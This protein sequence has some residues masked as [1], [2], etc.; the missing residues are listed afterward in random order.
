MYFQGFL[1]SSQMLGEGQ[2]FLL[3]LGNPFVQT[4]KLD[5]QL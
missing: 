2:Y 5:D 4:L 1:D 3:R